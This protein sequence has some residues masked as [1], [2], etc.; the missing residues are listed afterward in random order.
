MDT[1]RAD[2]LFDRVMQGGGQ[3]GDANGLLSEFARGYPLDRLRE[4]L[5]SEDP[6]VVSAGAFIASELGSRA[7]Q[8]I[9]EFGT[10]LGHPERRVRFDILDSVLVCAG[11]SQGPL[12]ARAASLVTDPDSAV[13]WKAYGFLA[14]AAESQ[15]A[16]ALPYAADRDLRTHLAWLAGPSSESH[17]EVVARL[18][19]VH[20][21]TR[22]FAVAAAARPGRSDETALE[23]AASSQDELAAKL[24]RQALDMLALEERQRERR[25]AR[26]RKE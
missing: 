11:E 21:F 15:L 1:S 24:A 26:K 2:E 3:E 9:D 18:G 23:I 19:S 16:A 13:R 14:R 12:I 25:E 20:E 8:L 5:R 10:L 22:R 17:E 6:A 4:L 7:G